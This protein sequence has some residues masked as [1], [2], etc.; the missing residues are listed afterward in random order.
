MS[1]QR[2]ILVHRRAPGD[3]VVMTGLV[4]DIATTYPG[5]FEIDVDTTAPELW[6]HNPYITPLRGQQ[7]PDVKTITMTYG[8]ELR[9]DHKYEPLHFLAAFHRNF[10]A[11]CGVD[12]PLTLPRPDLHL[13]PQERYASPVEGRYWL[14]VAGGKSDFTVKVWDQER[15]QQVVTELR[16]R[17]IPVVQVGATTPGHHHFPLVGTLNLVGK[18]TLRDMLRLIYHADGVICPI[19]CAMHMAA[20]LEKPCVVIAGG[21][22]AW[23]WEA[24]VPQNKG[25][26]GCEDKVRV[27]HK[28]LHT[29]GLLACCER[30]GCLKNKIVPLHNDPS[31]CLAP[32]RLAHGQVIPRCLDLI[33][34]EHVLEAVMEYYAD[35]SLPPIRLLTSTP[36]PTMLLDAFTPVAPPP[37][38]DAAVVLEGNTSNAI[39]LPEGPPV[40]E[41]RVLDAP[42][43]GGKFTICVWLRGGDAFFPRHRLCLTTL[44]ATVPQHRRCLR[45]IASGLE[46]ASQDFVRQV[47]DAEPE[48]IVYNILPTVGKYAAMRTVFWDDKSPL[49][50]KWVLWFDDDTIADRHPQW[51]TLLGQQIAQHHGPENAHLFGR[52][53]LWVPQQTHLTWMQ[54][55]PWWRGKGWNATKGDRLAYVQDGWFAVSTEAIR[56]CD[57][58]DPDADAYGG[59]ILLGAALHQYDMQIRSWNTQFQFLRMATSPDKDALRMLPEVNGWRDNPRLRKI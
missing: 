32:V 24:Y 46:S 48:V 36:K 10:H 52:K 47:R 59:P 29:I 3:T 22:E 37:Q 27:P 54:A 57:L 38:L 31:L 43:V 53:L 50:T 17:G 45:L 41:D 15:W 5:Q 20:A 2:L 51:L 35:G 21:R 4:R 7:R 18:T 6:R 39:G 25:F 12:V 1:P 34:P 19:T 13:S 23:W 9:H 49:T 33:Q 14:V 55:R 44:L 30:I 28:Y 16:R 58:P 40:E 56:T 42:D 26:L 11:Q 8:R